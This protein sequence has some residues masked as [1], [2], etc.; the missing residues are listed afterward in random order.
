M[1]TDAEN[2]ATI[3]S[4]ALARLAELSASPKP[5]YAIDGQSVSWN[6]YA[7]MLQEQIAWCDKQLA[8]ETPC[9]TITQGY[10]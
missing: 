6:E 7:Q 8:A 1:A 10:T 3:K 5:S 4:N 9:E 2:L